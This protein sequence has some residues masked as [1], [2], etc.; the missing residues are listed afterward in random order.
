VAELALL[1]QW[2]EFL[3]FAGLMIVAVVIFITIAHFYTYVPQTEP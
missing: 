3:F 1:P 2:Q